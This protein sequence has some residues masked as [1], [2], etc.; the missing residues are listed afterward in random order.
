ML[1]F[2]KNPL[3]QASVAVLLCAGCFALPACSSP[4]PRPSQGTSGGAAAAAWG[5]AAPAPAVAVVSPRDDAPAMGDA[6]GDPVLDRLLNSAAQN[7]PRMAEQELNIVMND[8]FRFRGWRQHLPFIHA[9]YSFGYFKLVRGDNRGNNETVGGTY[10]LGLRY[11][12]FDWGATGAEKDAARLREAIAMR[13]AK[14][15]WKQFANQIREDYFRAIILKNEIILKKL[16]NDLETR[17]VARVAAHGKAGNA[18]ANNLITQSV[19]L[20]RLNA[21]LQTATSELDNLA[22]SIR[23]ITGLDSFSIEDLPETVAIPDLDP[24]K[25]LARLEAFAPEANPGTLH[26]EFARLQDELA[27]AE[28][29]QARSRMLPSFNFGASI[30]Q[31]PVQTNTTRFEM[32]TVLFAG[33]NGYWNIFDREAVSTTVRAIKTR[34]RL[35]NRKLRSE[36]SYLSRSLASQVSHLRAL[37][38]QS[39]VRRNHLENARRTLSEMRQKLAFGM[40]EQ[41]AVEDAEVNIAALERGMLNDQVNIARAY[42]QFLSGIEQDPAV[43]LYT[44]P[45]NE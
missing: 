30:A 5:T 10:G 31:N 12:V 23:S 14:I 42:C 28:I 41:I 25:I 45:Q 18:S 43:S 7:S 11:P 39:E 27:D 26:A 2:K 19:T 6:I 24:G 29:T 4:S 9:S 1:F 3:G 8:A 17:R 34:K 37:L 16:Q 20:R 32:Q 44:P 38:L 35:I 21:E 33:I 22:A 36:N 40:V 15:A 13:S